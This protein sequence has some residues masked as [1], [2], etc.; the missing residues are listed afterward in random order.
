MP[1]PKK[2]E[3]RGARAKDARAE[4]TIQRQIKTNQMAK[5]KNKV[6]HEKPNQ[7][8]QNYYYK[9]QINEI[10]Q[11]QMGEK[12]KPRITKSKNYERKIECEEIKRKVS[13]DVKD[14]RN[15]YRKSWGRMKQPIFGIMDL[16]RTLQ[17]IAGE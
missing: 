6:L 3:A 1:E 14:F 8:R 7:K 5:T 9:I 15:K 13:N 11:K 12:R 4:T 2:P 17:V 16:F 10:S